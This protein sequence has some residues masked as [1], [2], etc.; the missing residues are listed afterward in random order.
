[1]GKVFVHIPELP[2]YQI[3][4]F[5]VL[6]DSKQ[7][8]TF[9]WHGG[10]VEVPVERD[11]VLEVKFG[12]MGK[13]VNV[14]ADQYSAVCVMQAAIGLRAS[15]T[16]CDMALVESGKRLPAKG[17]VII[18]CG[19]F[20]LTTPKYRVFV[21]DVE[22]GAVTRD[23]SKLE[24]LIDKPYQIVIKET[25][26]SVKKIVTTASPDEIK[27]IRILPSSRFLFSHE[28][29]LFKDGFRLTA[30]KAA[31]DENPSALKKVGKTLLKH[32]RAIMLGVGVVAALAGAD[33]DAA[34]MDADVDVGDD[35]DF[36]DDDM[37][38]EMLD[39]DGDGLADTVLAD[40]DGDGIADAI[41]MDTDGDGL[42]DSF[43]ADTDGDG[44]L[45]T[46]GMD[47]DGDGM[48]DT[49]GMDTN[50]DGAIDTVGLDT[51]GN[52][53]IDTVGMDT[54]G[55]GV[56]DTVDV[57]TESA[58]AIDTVS[59]D[60]DGD[61]LADTVVAD[62]DGDGVADAIGMDTDGDGV[63][64]SFGADTDGDG[65][66]DTF[67]VDS[68]GDGAIDTV[69]VDT[70]GDGAIDTVGLDTDGDGAIDSVGMDTDGDGNLDTVGFDTN[71]DGAIDTV[72]VDM[73][74]D[75]TI[76]RVG[77]DTD[78]DGTLDRV[79]DLAE[80]ESL[81]DRVNPL[82]AGAVAATAVSVAAKNT[83]KTAPKTVT[84]TATASKAANSAN[85]VYTAPEGKK[86][87]QPS[88]GQ[89]VIG[90]KKKFNALWLI[91]VVLLLLLG[92]ILALL[93][94]KP[95]A[96]KKDSF[97]HDFFAEYYN[98]EADR[99]ALFEKSLSPDLL[100]A[101]GANP[102]LIGYLTDAPSEVYGTLSVSPQENGLY[103]VVTKVY[104]QV[105]AY[106]VHVN[107]KL[108][109]DRIEELQ[110][111]VVPNS[112][113]TRLHVALI[114]YGAFVEKGELNLDIEPGRYG[115]PGRSLTG[116]MEV[117]QYGGAVEGM[118]EQG[119]I[120][121]AAGLGW[122][123][124]C[125]FSG[126]Y[127]TGLIDATGTLQDAGFPV[128]VRLVAAPGPDDLD[129]KLGEILTLPDVPAA[130]RS[131][132]LAA[133]ER[134]LFNVPDHSSFDQVEQDGY[135][136]EFRNLLSRSCEKGAAEAT[137]GEI[138]ED[139][140]LVYWYDGNGDG[141]DLGSRKFQIRSYDA[142]SATVL[143]HMVYQDFPNEGRDY[144][145]SLK[146]EGGKWLLDDWFGTPFD[147]GMKAMCKSYLG[148]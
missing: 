84:N 35:M 81:A 41:G 113:P 42:L 20:F 17:K 36:G 100:Q 123:G 79:G 6:L 137:E 116:M 133:A 28:T 14:R 29:V 94:L 99:Y 39:T 58:G 3:G 4:K 139:E 144:L 18:S 107:N 30:P 61:G 125:S 33:A 118:I 37:D 72:G 121:L 89:T 119:K 120:T 77:V 45:D 70:D 62:T 63:L 78:G 46:F 143:L 11:G 106:R 82:L 127:A 51:D 110:G 104:D 111:V 34:D 32:K 92:G 25:G 1:M 147:A 86:E 88:E 93:F 96:E 22:V 67:G 128:T 10:D 98:G 138:G 13:K 52:G 101:A 71:G 2:N 109:I 64:D 108:K 140:F 7:V 97:I 69:G 85:A 87:P 148:N 136:A 53:T 44:M 73:D 9:S 74:G 95:S 54:D 131:A 105:S 47:S 129:R 141:M 57:N 126:N 91:P 117:P 48:L 31:E 114:S 38:F 23:E 103:E 142:N 115:V 66:L 68:D 59:V 21:N 75:G 19:K 90:N 56:L 43:G 40:T 146:K 8:A 16:V 145:L 122:L 60:T 102:E 65:A 5:K 83:H 76:D 50:G 135:T 134:A 15:H 26:L 124:T 132:L 12:L 80:K 55:D 112:I 130:E 49:V 27:L 24:I